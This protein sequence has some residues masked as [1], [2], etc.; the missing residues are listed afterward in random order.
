MKNKPTT[1]KPQGLT[2]HRCCD[3]DSALLKW[4]RRDW[5]NAATQIRKPDNSPYKWHELKIAFFD[6]R[7]EGDRYAPLETCPTFDAAVGCPGHEKV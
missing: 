7:K 1:E 3:V 4:N 6:A 5:I 2:Y